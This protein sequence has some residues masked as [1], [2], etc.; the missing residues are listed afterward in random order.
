MGVFL[1][2]GQLNSDGGIRILLVISG[3]LVQ[4]GAGPRPGIKFKVRSVAR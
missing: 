2:R 4:S 3:V 1:A